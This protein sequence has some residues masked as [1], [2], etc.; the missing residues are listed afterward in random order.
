[1]VYSFSIRYRRVLFVLAAAVLSAVM[2]GGLFPQTALAHA[3]SSVT[4]S[5]NYSTQNLSVSISH[6]VST[7][8]T[9]YIK[10]VTI[11]RNSNQVAIYNYTSQPTTGTFTYYYNV[12]A[13]DG[14]S[15]S[16]RA[17]CSIGGSNSG[18]TNVNAP[19]ITKPTVMFTSPA[20]NTEVTDPTLTVS[21][22]ASDNKGIN[23]VQVKVNEGAWSDAVGKTTWTRQVTLV[24]GNNT[25]H[26]KA[27][28]TSDNEAE[29]TITVIYNATQ[30][31]DETPPGITIMSPVDGSDFDVENITV[32]GSS[33]DN[34]AVSMVE[35][36]V[37]EG[38]W[39][40]AAGTAVWSAYITLVEG[41]NTIEAR[42]TDTSNNTAVDSITVSHSP[43]VP[44]DTTS[45]ELTIEAPANGT[46]VAMDEVTVSGSASD[47]RGVALV[48][49]R[50]N[51]GS[52]NAASGT[53]S[54][55]IKLS[56]I[57]GNN[58]IYVT[59]WDDAGNNVTASIIVE[60]DP[61]EPPDTEDPVV[62][63]TYPEEDQEFREPG[64]TVT[65]TASDNSCTCR[66]EVSIDGGNWQLA[67]GRQTW[68]IEVQ[69]TP[70]PNVI[71]ARAFDDSGNFGFDTVTVTYND[72]VPP[73]MVPPEIEITSPANGTTVNDPDLTVTGTASDNE[74]VDL[75]EV[76][77][78]DASWELAEGTT[79]WSIDL[80]LVEG[81]NTI[82]ARVM[83]LEGNENLS[84]IT[85]I[86]EVPYV[87]GELDGM[88]TDGEYR[89]SESLD[90]GNFTVYWDFDGDIW[91]VALKV[92]TTGWVS[93]GL[94][95]S[96][97]M[98]DADMIIGWVD[99]EDRVYIID[100]FSTGVQGP[101]PP[102][103]DLGG[104][105]DI[106]DFGGTEADGW[107]TIEFTRATNSSDSND[108]D[109]YDGQRMDIIWGYSTADD[110]TTY[111]ELTRGTVSDFDF[112]VVKQEPIPDD[113]DDITGDDD[114]K[115][116][117]NIGLFIALGVM[118]PIVV[119]LIIVVLVILLMRSKGKKDEEE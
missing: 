60:Y 20:N 49:A 90:D 35:V 7:P 66:V 102:D 29:T 110:F 45:P 1:M 72:T 93:I 112:T 25:I 39:S 85:V 100:A 4:V 62:A 95:P 56:L 67:T 40:T 22:T 44:P 5:Y 99:D 23:K 92:K 10:T 87:P 8:S 70:G 34:E 64:I 88:I 81:E 71:E 107:T 14:D 117:G 74:E 68:S 105:D 65:G 15:L 38:E 3:P 30:P 55:S 98:K 12:T 26:A 11:F 82:K 31:P 18:S 119:V 113:D 94:G 103:T 42:A 37:N 16:A 48:E 84:Q 24:E 116:S 51:N 73:D 77:L 21:G 50:V 106:I 76:M 28:D 96:T 89:A 114:D 52:W 104:T 83:D 46:V 36:R 61:G 101:H 9:H 32:S 53:T 108:K 2:L 69:L 91:K 57:E 17:D 41:N 111:H 13:S 109:V 33:S 6:S 79:S 47:D 43:Q 54:W 115:E 118:I 80:I 97:Q 59:A 27:I 78:N 86:Y 58:T 63:I 75:I 19:D